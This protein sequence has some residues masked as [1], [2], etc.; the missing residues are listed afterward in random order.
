M[1]KNK[2]VRSSLS[3]VARGPSYHHLKYFWTVVEEGTITKASQRLRLAQPTISTQLRKLEENLGVELFTRQGRR[4]IVTD[5][6]RVVHR[7][8]DEILKLGKE[9]VDVLGD[10]PPDRPLRLAVGLTLVVPKLVAYELLRPALELT[11]GVLVECH[12]DKVSRLLPLLASHELD[13]VISDAPLGPGVAVKAYNHPLGESSTSFMAARALASGLRTGF[14]NSLDRAPYLMPMGGSALRRELERW[15]SEL[16]VRPDIVGEFDDSALLK[17]FGQSGV[18]AFAVPTVIEEQVKRQY[19]V[20]VVGRTHEVTERFYAISAE[21]KFKH[22][23]VLAIVNVA[24]TKI[25]G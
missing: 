8:A 11:P 12:E 21:R 25:F 9:M 7:Y 1:A 15:F 6:G 14:P 22:P 5:A 3:A 16:H 20:E 2:K 24:R 10:R 17:V 23:G 4:L 19:G 13:L 18:G